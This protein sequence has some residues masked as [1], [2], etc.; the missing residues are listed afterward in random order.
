M[1]KHVT[2]DAPL[3]EIGT[4]DE[5]TLRAQLSTRLEH[6]K[7][8]RER[9]RE[10]TENLEK[11]RLKASEGSEVHLKKERQTNYCHHFI[12]RTAFL[13]QGAGYY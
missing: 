10:L 12:G 6:E 13:D 5:D 4:L 9:L 7:E 3:P 2:V 1:S 8:E 11:E